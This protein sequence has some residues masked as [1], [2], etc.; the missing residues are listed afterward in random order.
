MAKSF[1]DIRIVAEEDDEERLEN[2]KVG[3]ETHTPLPTDDDELDQ[4]DS[5]VDDNDDDESDLLNKAIKPIYKKR[6]D[7]TYTLV[8]DKVYEEN[9]LLENIADS[10]KK[11]ATRH[12]TQAVRLKDGSSFKV[13]TTTANMILSVHGALNK[14]NQI[15]M[16]QILARDK[17]GFSKMARFAMAQARSGS[18][19]TIN[20]QI[21]VTQ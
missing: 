11:I 7:G 17:A 15:K 8:Q 5:N 3:P 6:K 10:L 18:Q 21:P 14:N 9:Q 2:L 4:P 19:V 16:M 20:Q 12:Q 13:D 1:R